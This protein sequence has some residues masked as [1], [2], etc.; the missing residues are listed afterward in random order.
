MLCVFSSA[1]LVFDLPYEYQT[2]QSV[3][4]VNTKTIIWFTEFLVL[5]LMKYEKC[6]PL[7]TS[8]TGKVHHLR[9]LLPASWPSK[10][11][12]MSKILCFVKQCRCYSLV[13]Q[14]KDRLCKR[15]PGAKKSLRRLTMYRNIQW[16]VWRIG[17]LRVPSF[18]YE[19]LRKEFKS[20]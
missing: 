3:T 11:S 18:Q 9:H 10:H 6:R 2:L 17:V 14:R 7:R 4:S 19:R 13:W 15:N 16:N 8:G 5:R 20:N 12:I 1:S